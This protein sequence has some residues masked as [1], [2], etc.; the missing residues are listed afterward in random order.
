[1]LLESVYDVCSVFTR[2]KM[3]CQKSSTKI[4]RR[5]A[6]ISICRQEICGAADRS[7]ETSQVLVLATDSPFPKSA[8][9]QLEVIAARQDGDIPGHVILAASMGT[10]TL[11]NNRCMQM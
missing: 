4:F 9:L 6:P 3:K 10:H 11:V 8:G 1:M 7:L 5:G 2:Q